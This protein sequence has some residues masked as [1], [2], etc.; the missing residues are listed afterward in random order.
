MGDKKEGQ[1]LCDTCH[2]SAHEQKIVLTDGT[3]HIYGCHNIGV[4]GWEYY[5]KN[6]KPPGGMCGLLSERD[7][8]SCR[9]MG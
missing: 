6:Q 9:D 7:L 4:P 3:E 2:W 5:E 8:L 1:S